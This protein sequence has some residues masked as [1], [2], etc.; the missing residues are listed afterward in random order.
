MSDLTGY[1]T[2]IPA[3]KPIRYDEWNRRAIQRAIRGALRRANHW[4]SR[5]RAEAMRHPTCYSMS[6]VARKPSSK[7]WTSIPADKQLEEPLTSGSD[8][9]SDASFNKHYG[10]QT[11]V[12]AV[13]EHCGE[14]TV[15]IAI[16]E[17]KRSGIR[18]AIRCQF[19]HANRRQSHRQVLQRANC[20][21][22]R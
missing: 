11:V 8:E 13:V 9:R 19:R 2:T 1:S 10:T 16:D 12:K 15:G 18:C 6:I 21:K 7:P 14:Q 5:R 3:R 20:W 22:S 17:R 4:D